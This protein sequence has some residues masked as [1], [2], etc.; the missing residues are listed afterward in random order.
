MFG[1]KFLI[2]IIRLV[3]PRLD[4]KLRF[5]FISPTVLRLE[6]QLVRGDAFGVF[7][8]EDAFERRPERV[9]ALG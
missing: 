9:D 7:E 3:D 6:L 4:R 2:F 1:L 5:R 8:V